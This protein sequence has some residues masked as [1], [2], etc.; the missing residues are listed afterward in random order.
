MKVVA[1]KTGLNP[2]VIRVWERRYGVVTPAR[3]HG[4]RR[5]YSDSEI[6]RLRLLQDATRAGHSIGSIAKLSEEDLRRLLERDR[7]TDGAPL[8]VTGAGGGR[9]QATIQ[10]NDRSRDHVGE[11][12][13]AVRNLDTPG[14]ERIL[15]RAAAGLGQ[16]GLLQEVMVPLIHRVGEEWRTGTLKVAHEHAASAVIR[17]LLVNFAHAYELPASAPRLIVT[18][19]PGHLHEL[20]AILVAVTASHQGWHSTYLGPS[21]PAEEIAGAA[22]QNRARAVA[23]SVVYPEDDLNLESELARLHRLLPPDIALLVGGRASAAYDYLLQRIKAFRIDDLVGLQ[24][25]LD[26]LRRH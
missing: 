11:A 26:E 1:R 16:F 13:R 10:A 9:L 17:H 14:L 22:V 6:A 15:S 23:L 19:P 2:H 4:N 18:T 24:A 21:L 7:E 12:L 25:K 8:Q 5:L 3:S 20:G